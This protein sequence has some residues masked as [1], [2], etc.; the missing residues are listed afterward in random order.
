MLGFFIYLDT[1][2]IRKVGILSYVVFCNF[3]LSCR[4][5]HKCLQKI[6]FYRYNNSLEQVTSFI[7]FGCEVTYNYGGNSKTRLSIFQQVCGTVNRA[8][9]K[10]AQKETQIKF[11][12]MAA[13][14]CYVGWRLGTLTRNERY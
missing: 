2:I 3:I 6:H 7:Y 8:M 9:K 12:K 1:I 11:Y 14:F 13:L 5:I 4:P 10:G